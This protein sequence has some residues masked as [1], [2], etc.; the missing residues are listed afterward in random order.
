MDP[1][2]HGDNI[3]LIF[4][5][6]YELYYD[7][8]KPHVLCCIFMKVLHQI[9]KKIHGFIHDMEATHE[10]N[11]VESFDVIWERVCRDI[12]SMVDYTIRS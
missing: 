5:V 7:I 11:F 2:A 6:V 4:S 3:P 8:S 1:F 12:Y 10:A 9:G